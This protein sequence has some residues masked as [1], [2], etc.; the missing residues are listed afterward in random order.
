MALE[1]RRR[2]LAKALLPLPVL[3]GRAGVGVSLLKNARTVPTL[4]LFWGTGRGKEMH[5]RCSAGKLSASA[6]SLRVQR[7]A[8]AL[9]EHVELL[10]G[11]PA[12][13]EVGADRPEDLVERLIGEHVAL[14][15]CPDVLPRRRPGPPGL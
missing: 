2:R 1:V 8:G 5:V 14:D 13:A 4:T 11:D 7:G 9:V 3:R 10:L 15:Q 6:S 12:A